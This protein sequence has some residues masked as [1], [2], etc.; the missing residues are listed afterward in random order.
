MKNTKVIEKILE[1]TELTTSGKL[2][3]YDAF[4]D[5]TPL[6]KIYCPIDFPE[7]ISIYK[8]EE[9]RSFVGIEFY[10]SYEDNGFETKKVFEF[11]KVDSKD[12]YELLNSLFDYIESNTEASPYRLDY[13]EETITKIEELINKLRK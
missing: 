11:N 10:K 9:F 8:S 5:S 6:H 2:K 3:W 4:D 1:L 13:L 12:D 7:T